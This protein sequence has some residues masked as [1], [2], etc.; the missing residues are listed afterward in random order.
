MRSANSELEH[1]SQKIGWPRS[2]RVLARFNRARSCCALS[3]QWWT[4]QTRNFVLSSAVSSKTQ[5]FAFAVARL[6][7]PI[8]EQLDFRVS[9]VVHGVVDASVTLERCF[10]WPLWWIMAA[11]PRSGLRFVTAVG[12]DFNDNDVGAV[13]RSVLLPRLSSNAHV[14]TRNTQLLLPGDLRLAVRKM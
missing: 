1:P 6:T 12:A 13:T 7:S 14:P 8:S 3:W 5:R 2:T 11:S 10:W 9:A 4:L